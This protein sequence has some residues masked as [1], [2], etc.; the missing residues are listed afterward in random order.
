[1][2]QLRRTSS[3]YHHPARLEFPYVGEGSLPGPHDLA[4]E[5]R[6]LGIVDLDL[7]ELGFMTYPRPVVYTV[8]QPCQGLQVAHPLAKVYPAKRSANSSTRNRRFGANKHTLGINHGHA[9]THCRI[10]YDGDRSTG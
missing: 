9:G 4:A 3:R 6:V 5:V 10:F 7:F 1:M 8:V 2:A